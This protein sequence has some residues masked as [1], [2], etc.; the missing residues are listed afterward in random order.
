MGDRVATSTWST[1]CGCSATPTTGASAVDEAWGGRNTKVQSQVLAS[2][3]RTVASAPAEMTWVWVWAGRAGVSH[4]RP[5]QV[6]QHEW[7]LP[8]ACAQPARRH[9]VP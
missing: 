4:R 2:Q 9:H 3:T 8:V 1:F 7:C 5:A 6:E